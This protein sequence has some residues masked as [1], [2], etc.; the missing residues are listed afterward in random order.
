MAH[1]GVSGMPVVLTMSL[2]TRKPTWR[3][4]ET[5]A[6]FSSYATWEGISLCWCVICL[7]YEPRPKCYIPR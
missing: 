1:P 5:K 4:L 6:D 3:D 7:T 2:I